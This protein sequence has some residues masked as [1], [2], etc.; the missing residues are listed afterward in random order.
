[1]LEDKIE[2]FPAVRIF[3]NGVF[4]GIIFNESLIHFSNTPMATPVWVAVNKYG[5][6]GN[7]ASKDQAIDFLV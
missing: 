1:M 3:K 7:Y 5:T 4:V 6:S 2:E